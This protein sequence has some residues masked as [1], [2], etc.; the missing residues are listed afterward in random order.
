MRTILIGLALVLGG[1][2]G[3]DVTSQYT[4]V[5]AQVCILMDREGYSSGDCTY[6]EGVRVVELPRE[7]LRDW[8]ACTVG[9]LGCYRRDLDVIFLSEDTSPKTPGK[10]MAHEYLHA[11]M[12]HLD[13]PGSRE[14]AP[15]FWELEGK[16]GK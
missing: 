16:V 12:E 6:L 2:S 9:V 10:V 11:A 5:R 7:G 13:I 15:L 8:W 4:G 14:H 3:H 1:C